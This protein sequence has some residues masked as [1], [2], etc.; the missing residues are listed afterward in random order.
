M[1]GSSREDAHR[2]PLGIEA[3]VVCRHV[4]LIKFSSLPQHN[5]LSRPPH[6]PVQGTHQAA[7]RKQAGDLE[8]H[9]PQGFA[10]FV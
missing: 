2:E 4:R 10:T 9:H 1:L 5:A 6:P 8:V 7:F 3:G